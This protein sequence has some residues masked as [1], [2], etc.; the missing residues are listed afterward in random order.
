MTKRK[1]TSKPKRRRRS[2]SEEFKREAV[3]LLLHHSDRGSQY[4]SQDYRDL[5]RD[6]NITCS[7]S[8]KADRKVIPCRSTVIGC[9]L[10]IPR[11]SRARSSS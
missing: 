3:K 7:M 5:L 4:A 9:E 1:A 11:S 6:H 10:S 8:R 2:H